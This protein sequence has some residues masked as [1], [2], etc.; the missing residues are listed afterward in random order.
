MHFFFR[1]I[2]MLKLR[3]AS[4]GARRFNTK[5]PPTL[6]YVLKATRKISDTALPKESSPEDSKP[7]EQPQG[8]I[9][10]NKEASGTTDT[11]SQLLS[12]EKQKPQ[13]TA[14]ADDELRQKMASLAG[15]GGEAGV[16]LEDGRPVSMKRGVKDNL[17]RYI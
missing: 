14:E 13:T 4:K 12:P 1:Y 2:S 15:D 5:W 8:A 6:G 16:E 17:F 11:K 7:K 10:P 3:R 9:D